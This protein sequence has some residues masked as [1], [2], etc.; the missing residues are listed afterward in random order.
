MADEQKVSQLER[1]IEVNSKKMEIKIQE[2]QDAL[3]SERKKS[4]IDDRRVQEIEK[5]LNEKVYV[6]NELTRRKSED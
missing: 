2:L 5:K 1:L 6:Y 3:D 4:M